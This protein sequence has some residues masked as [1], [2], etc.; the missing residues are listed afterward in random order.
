MT[1]TT[2]AKAIL[3]TICA[4]LCFGVMDVAV[5]AVSPATGTIPALWARYAGQMLIVVVLVAPRLRRVAR[6][7]YPKLQFARSILLMMATF[8]SFRRLDRSVWLKRRP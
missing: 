2:N 5:K 6:S 3:L 4:I 7:K 8:F 1:S